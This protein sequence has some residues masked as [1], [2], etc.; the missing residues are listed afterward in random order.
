MDKINKLEIIKHILHI[1]IIIEFLVIG[2]NVITFNQ[3]IEAI[4]EENIHLLN[5]N[6]RL[7]NENERLTMMNNE[8]WELFR[9]S[10]NGEKEDNINE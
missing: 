8:I 3:K 7:T 4:R 6:E 5:E 2:L 1:I 9:S 10:Y